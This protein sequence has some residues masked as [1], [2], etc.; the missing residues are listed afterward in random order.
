MDLF[1]QKWYL[2]FLI[3][4][5]GFPFKEQVFF[6]FMTAVTI[7]SDFGAQENKIWSVTAST[8]SPIC[9]KVIGAYAMILVLSVEFQTNIFTLPFHPHKEAL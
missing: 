9:H 6:N 2:C 7:H 3:H 4:Y 5:L 8:Y 1:Q